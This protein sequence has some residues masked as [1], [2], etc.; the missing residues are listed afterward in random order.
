MRSSKSSRKS[1]ATQG[2]IK[3]QAR[4]KTKKKC[5]YCTHTPDTMRKIHHSTREGRC[6]Q[7]HHDAAHACGTNDSHAARQ[8]HTL[9]SSRAT[10]FA[11]PALYQSHIF[12]VFPSHFPTGLRH[13]LVRQRCTIVFLRK[14]RHTRSSMP[15]GG[16]CMPLGGKNLLVRKTESA[17]S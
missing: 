15:L 14:I 1:R 13:T 6:K 2:I 10:A 5:R 3:P 17:T 9:D 8:T 16:S 7:K 12:D 4:V 11:W